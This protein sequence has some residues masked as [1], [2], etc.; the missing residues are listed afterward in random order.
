MHDAHQIRGHLKT[1]NRRRQHD[2]AALDQ[3]IAAVDAHIVAGRP[4][5]LRR[6]TISAI[7]A[8]RRMAWAGRIIAL[9]RS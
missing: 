2:A 7:G 8:T 1:L 4:N 9:F 6:S 3:R 5:T